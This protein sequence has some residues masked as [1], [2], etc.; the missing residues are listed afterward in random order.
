MIKIIVGSHVGEGK[1]TLAQLIDVLLQER[2]FT[3]TTLIDDGDYIK[4]NINR[5]IDAI[6]TSPIIIET[7]QFNRESL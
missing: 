7:V 3:N 1:S 6:K 2:G 5:C 4:E